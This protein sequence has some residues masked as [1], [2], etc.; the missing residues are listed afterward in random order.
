MAGARRTATRWLDDTEQASWRAFIHSVN[1][2]M[3]ATEADLA[4]HGITNGDYAVVGLDEVALMPAL[5]VLAVLPLAAFVVVPPAPERNRSVIAL[6]IPYVAGSCVAMVWVRADPDTGFSLFLYLLLTVWATDTGA[7]VV[8]RW[9]GGPR[10][11]PSISPSKTWAGLI[12]GMLAAAVVGGT[13][14]LLAAAR[15]PWFAVM[16]AVFLTGEQLTLA[17]TAGI[18]LILGGV[19]VTITAPK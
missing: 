5:M 17:T 15:S 18:A 8:G 12:G 14:A 16:L 10:L 2:L 13:V 19:F 3:A 1:D 9:W 6:G 11:A 4:H 7:Y